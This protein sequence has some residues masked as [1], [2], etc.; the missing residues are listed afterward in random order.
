MIVLFAPYVYEKFKHLLCLPS[1][2]HYLFNVFAPMLKLSKKTAIMT[3]A[4]VKKNCLHSNWCHSL[5]AT[6][7]CDCCVA[8]SDPH[9]LQFIFENGE[10]PKPSSFGNYLIQ[11]K[12]I[13]FILWIQQKK[14]K[15]GLLQNLRA[16]GIGFKCNFSYFSVI[17]WSFLWPLKN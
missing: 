14:K 16:F 2:S 6:V 7:F 11:T 1:L 4:L 8:T 15:K 17:N 10:Q 3:T 12:K 9:F 5:S 13:Y